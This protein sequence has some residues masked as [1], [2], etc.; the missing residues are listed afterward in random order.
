MG[1]EGHYWGWLVKAWYTTPPTH[2]H[3]CALESQM[4][5]F[6]CP[7]DLL[8]NALH[9]LLLLWPL[10][11]NMSYQLSS[12]LW[13][14][15]QQSISLC[16]QLALKA[17]A[18]THPGRQ[19]S[20]VL[21]SIWSF[22]CR[23]WPGAQQSFIQIFEC[24]A[25]L[26]VRLTPSEIAAKLSPRDQLK[27]SSQPPVPFTTVEGL[28]LHECEVGFLSFFITPVG[29]VGVRPEWGFRALG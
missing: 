1:S 13:T 29:P 14:G 22:C 4:S 25:F 2:T 3:A 15:R 24:T 6:Q 27:L 16:W 11:R 17:A 19:T 5:K 10:L 26:V 8:I 28:M 12:E 20:C 7:K 9:V 23:T 18:V 21:A